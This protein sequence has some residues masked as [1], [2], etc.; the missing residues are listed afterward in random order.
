M[1]YY[2]FLTRRPQD[3]QAWPLIYM[4]KELAEAAPFRVSDVVEVDLEVKATQET[5]DSTKGD[6]RG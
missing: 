5:V 6:S 4:S 1:T 2:T 3:K